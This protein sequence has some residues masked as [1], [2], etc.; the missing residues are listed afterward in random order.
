MECFSNVEGW[1]TCFTAS[2]CTLNN[3]LVYCLFIIIIVHEIHHLHCSLPIPITPSLL[4]HLAA[5]Y[6]PRSIGYLPQVLAIHPTKTKILPT[7][8]SRPTPMSMVSPLDLSV[9]PEDKAFDFLTCPLDDP[10]DDLFDQYIN[11]DP[12]ES[13]QGFNDSSASCEPENPFEAGNSSSGSEPAGTSPTTA[14]NARHAQL[15]QPCWTAGWPNQQNVASSTQGYQTFVQQYTGNEAAFSEEENLSLEGIL[16]PSITSHHRPSSPPSTPPSTASR[17][18]SKSAVTTPKTIRRRE[19]DVRKS[20]NRNSSIS[21]RM[22]RPSHYHAADLPSYQE[23]TQRFENFNLDLPADNLPMSPP[24]STRVSQDEKMTRFIVPEAAEHNQTDRQEQ[25]FSVPMGS[26]TSPL[27]PPTAQMHNAQRVALQRRITTDGIG[28]PAAMYPHIDVH[29]PQPQ[30]QNRASWMSTAEASTDLDFETPSNFQPPSE[31]WPTGVPQPSHPYYQTAPTA[32]R[33]ASQGIPQFPSDP[34]A[35]QGLLISCEPSGMPGN[36]NPFVTEDPSG[37][38]FTTASS[39]LFNQPPATKQTFSPRAPSPPTNHHQHHPQPLRSRSPSASP[40]STPHPPT[41]T[42][43]H[44][45]HHNHHQKSR[46]PSSKPPS[47]HHRRKS[48]SSSTPHPPK[49]PTTMPPTPTVGFVNFTPNDS[50]KLLAAVAPSGSS[51]TK[52]KREKEANERRRKLS[53]AAVRAVQEAGGDVGAL[54][55]EG[56]L[57]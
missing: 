7:G 50:K 39:D 5:S 11:L 8:R 36:H 25:R 13:S 45:N 12:F 32:I 46:R 22:M 31:W 34:F 52:M 19:L 26:I 55:A 56:L 27:S 49:T 17:K 33:H 42:R 51:K 41:T 2:S 9:R 15:H 20:S 6:Y 28:Y 21:P 4:R 30:S 54:R 24:P 47:S 43:T 57:I 18:K 48:S 44:H 40:T 23:W 29:S 10:F 14:L 3:S 37:N 35:S 16:R 1:R 38:Y 53:L